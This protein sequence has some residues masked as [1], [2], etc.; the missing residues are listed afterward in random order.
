[1]DFSQARA[2]MVQEQLVARDIH[3]PRVLQAM[4]DVP[5]ELF[6]PPEYRLESYDDTPL[7]IG[8]GQTISQPY[9]VALMTETLRLQGHEIVL[10]VGTG[11]GY[12]AAILAGLAGQVWSVE[13][14]P[15]LAARARQVL[16]QMAG[17]KV[18]IV[19]GDG[20]Q[21]LPGRAP[22]DAIMITA[23]SPQVPEPLLEQLRPGGRMVLPVGPRRDQVLECWQQRGQ[24]WHIER[25]SQVRFV[26][27]V[28]RWG[29]T[30]E[31]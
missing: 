15:V 20:S 11:S 16:G 29:W 1:M 18:E 24:A 27:L 19:V 5:R 13:K 28:G 21:G 22:F 7:P 6:V 4:G 12:Q 25:L 14:Y 8:H 26:P 17:Q 10:E 2:R 23:A 9:I 3:D 31:R 30:E